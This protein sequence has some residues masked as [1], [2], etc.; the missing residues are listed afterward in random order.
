[1]E[2]QKGCKHCR[3]QHMRDLPCDSGERFVI[4]EESIWF[5]SGGEA[6]GIDIRFCPWCGRDLREDL[7]EETP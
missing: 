4:S 2:N 6:I 5:C 7:T 3:S 1:M